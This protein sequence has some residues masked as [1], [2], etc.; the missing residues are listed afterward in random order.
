MKKLKGLCL[1][2]VAAMIVLPFS[3]M[4]DE[5]DVVKIGI[6]LA[7]TGTL[8]GYGIGMVI[9][10]E[11]A[12]EDINKS[13]GILGK[14]VKLVHY[15]TASDRKQVVN[16]VRKMIDEDIKFLAGPLASQETQQVFPIINEAKVICMSGASLAPGLPDPYP[17]AFRNTASEAK[18]VPLCVEYVKEL[19]NPKTAVLFQVHDD[20][21]GKSMGDE[22]T[23]ALAKNNIPLK[24]T[25][26]YNQGETD[27]SARVT[28]AMSTKPDLMVLAG[29]YNEQA[30]IMLEARRQGFKGHFIDGAGFSSPVIFD[31]AGKAAN[32]SFFVSTWSLDNPETKKFAERFRARAGKEPQQSDGNQYDIVMVIAQAMKNAG[33]T[34]DPD[35]VRQA[36]NNIKNFR[37]PSGILGFDKKSR[38]AIRKGYP[39]LLKDGKFVLL[40]DSPKEAKGKF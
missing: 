30:L 26:P 31:I 11:M 36:L 8:S 20:P 3:A 13:G 39:T 24:M 40:P 35:K 10:S 7:I 21:Y 5:E 12:V 25:L 15:D 6:P 33:T 17:F 19:W 14:K 22:F 28:R 32:G 1:L 4:A 27:F 37:G 2:I 9:A 16:V 34:T 29:L 23:K 38:D 18:L